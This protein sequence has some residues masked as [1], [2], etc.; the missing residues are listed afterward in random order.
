M[1]YRHGFASWE[2]PKMVLNI[3]NSI[4]DSAGPETSPWYQTGNQGSF[5]CLGPSF[6]ERDYVIKISDSPSAA[7]SFQSPIH[8]EMP[9]DLL[10][11]V[12]RCQSF[13]VWPT[14]INQSTK[15]VYPL[16][17]MFWESKVAYNVDCSRPIGRRVSQVPTTGQMPFLFSHQEGFPRMSQSCL[18]LPAANQ[19]QMFVYRYF[20]P[21]GFD[22]TRIIIPPESINLQ[23][24]PVRI[25]AMYD[26]VM[27][28]Y[29]HPEHVFIPTP[30]S[31]PMAHKSYDFGN[32]KI[33]F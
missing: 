18:K 23:N 2:F 26:Q 28:R 33:K 11:R 25:A 9:D 10:S 17:A 7:I 15:E 30:I 19:A 27:E 6:G 21:N 32:T 16:G 29:H 24:W 5:E 14:V 4:S 8:N 1:T 31:L 12:E 3:Q 22:S 13:F 20:K